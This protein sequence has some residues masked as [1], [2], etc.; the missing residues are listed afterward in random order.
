LVPLTRFDHTIDF[1]GWRLE[2]VGGSEQPGSVSNKLFLDIRKLLITNLLLTNGPRENNDNDDGEDITARIKP[3]LMQAAVIFARL[4][5][6]CLDDAV[7]V[8]FD[9]INCYNTQ[10]GNRN[11]R[12][13]LRG[14]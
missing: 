3:I 14:D 7:F 13:H 4:Y 9:E 2:R 8:S 5:Y 6:Y 12:V 11:F 10:Y 1:N